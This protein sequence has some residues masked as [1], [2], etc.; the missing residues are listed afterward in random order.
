MASYGPNSKGG[1]MKGGKALAGGVV[2]APK[3]E[4]QTPVSVGVKRLP[5]GT[6]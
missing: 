2:T 5:R 6:K 3:A 1:K 4:K